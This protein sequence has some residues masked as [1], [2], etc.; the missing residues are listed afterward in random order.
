VTSDPH[1]LQR[2][3]NAQ[4]RIYG[5]VCD[6]LRSGQKASHWMWF[7]FPQIKGLGSSPTA[8]RYAIT[9]IEEAKAYLAH[10]LLGFRLRECTQLANAVNGRSSEEIF[11]Y[12][13][14]LKFHSSM[15]L[16]AKASGDE[17]PFVAALKKYFKAQADRKTLEQ[18]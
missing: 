16:F 12:P 4:H 15:T 18:L 3:L 17:P 13:D 5:Q 7:I 10:D 11:G 14:H 2:F 9:G 1:D 6:E 8:Q